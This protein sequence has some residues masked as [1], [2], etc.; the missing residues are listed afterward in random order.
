MTR[1]SVRYLDNLHA[2]AVHGPS[3]AT[4]QTDAP[5]DHDGL[6]QSFAP[7]DLLAAS[8]GTCLL[9]IMGIEA[10]KMGWT[11]IGA[12][13]TVDKEIAP[14]GPRRVGA[15]RATVTMPSNLTEAQLLYLKTA[16]YRCPVLVTL[17]DSVDITITWN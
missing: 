12:T 1:I 7:T 6:G 8:L 11:F 3:D 17:Q 4:L 9:T 5:T 15:L 10:K 2:E 16:A 14:E 13:A